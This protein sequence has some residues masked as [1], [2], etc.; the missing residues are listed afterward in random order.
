MS[1]RVA[2][3]L[4]LSCSLLL[5]GCGKD[6]GKEAES[7][8]SD[9]A[10]TGALAD[11]IMVDPDLANQNR[12]GAAIAGGGPATA[13]IPP[14]QKTPEA[15]AAAKAEAARL[16]GGTIASAPAPVTGGDGDAPL[17]AEEAAQS[18]PGGG[19][20]G[21]R[22][23]DKVEYSAN[24]ATR[25][26]AAFP[27][28]PRAHVQEAAGTDKDGCHLRVVNFVTPVSVQDVIDFYYTRARAAGFEA[29]HRLEGKDHVIGGSSGNAAYVIYARTGPG[30]VTDVDLVAQGG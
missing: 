3:V 6:A 22:C 26:P 18:V 2:T 10:L 4:I 9:P 23:A 12:G 16:A 30:G 27:V 24:W 14:I 29:E 1:A 5:A 17:T 21:A 13:E 8:A 28:Y 19:N 25:L 7:D 15:I 20:G 11:Q